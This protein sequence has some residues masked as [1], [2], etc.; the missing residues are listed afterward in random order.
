[1]KTYH[2]HFD[3]RGSAYDQA[4]RRY[5]HARDQEFGQVISRAAIAPGMRLADVPAGGGYLAAYLPEGCEWLPHEP[6][7]AF[8][9]HH[10]GAPAQSCPLLPLPWNDASID[11]AVSLAGVH[12]I[13]DKR[14]LYADLYRV[15]RPGG[16]LVLSDASDGSKVARF[17]DGF[18]GD[19]NSTGHEG[20]FL[21]PGTAGELEASG[22]SVRS[23][24]QV[25]Y[26]WVFGS[27]AAMADFCRILF[28]IAK[29]SPDQV[30][31]AIESELGVDD[32]PNGGVGMRWSLMTF[33][34]D[35]P[36]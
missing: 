14:P 25:D 7:A 29:A 13:D 8:L 2:D 9:N 28:D 22:W 23:T 36:V 35:K 18:V 15:A 6:S 3:L 5:P 10:G 17:L 30:R 27:R 19:F 1:M 33:V 24:E 31:H 4:M 26:H 32:L 34:A 20:V 16:R 12:H 21:H 11:V